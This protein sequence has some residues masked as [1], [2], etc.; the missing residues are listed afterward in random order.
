MPASHTVKQGEH[1]SQIAQ[2]YG[3]RDFHVIWDDAANAQ[4]KSLRKNPNVLFPGDVLQIP[5]KT[6]RK[7]TRPTTKVHVFQ[8]KSRGLK[9]SLVLRDYHRRPVANTECELEIDGAK[10]V[11]KTDGNG[12]FTEVISPSMKLGSVKAPHVGL[13]LPLKIGHLDPVDTPSGQVA[14]LANMGYYRGSIQGDPD[15]DELNSA[16][17]EFQCDHDLQVD[18]DCGPQTQAKLNEIHGC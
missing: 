14:R 5:D 7:E 17:Q 13:D 15:P 2:Q 8:V 11:V 9:L 1:L 6:E 12:R 4:L 10:K 16:I 18:G 3:F